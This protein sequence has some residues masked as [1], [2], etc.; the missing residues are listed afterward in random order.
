M[1]V[2]IYDIMLPEIFI[3]RI[4]K[5]LSYED[6]RNAKATCKKWREF[7]FTLYKIDNQ[8]K[9]KLRIMI[10]LYNFTSK[11]SASFLDKVA[12][13]N[14]VF[15]SGAVNY[16]RDCNENI[17]S[18]VE[19]IGR[20]TCN[21]PS[22]P[23]SYMMHSMTINNASELMVIGGKNEK[24]KHCYVY[25]GC[26]W[27]YHSSLNKSRVSFCSVSML[28]GIY[29][30]GCMPLQSDTNIQL[31]AEHLPNGKSI[32]Q[33]LDSRI[34]QPGI[35]AAHAVA[36]SP[37]EILFTGNKHLAACRRI[38]TFNISTKQWTHHG[39]FEKPRWFHSSFVYRIR[40]IISGG[41]DNFGAI[42]STEIITLQ[43]MSVKDG[44]DLNE[45][46]Y[47][48][49]MGIIE[50]NGIQRLVAFGG[51]DGHCK[52]KG[53]WLTSFEV[54]NDSLECWEKTDMKLSEPLSYFGYCSKPIF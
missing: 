7:I 15:V 36:I 39:H 33:N 18:K 53:K 25:K 27:V 19:V 4:F 10:S 17:P 45:A 2:N 16:G 49:G 9:C 42:N 38:L 35:T 44:G 13:H 8:T 28:D 31:T 5:Y 43:T 34:P 11:I 6:L 23:K 46:R 50:I 29:V 20:Y 3:Y 40:V 24:F 41:T 52:R 26:K 32:W 51:F 14:S 30:F 37:N 54:W 48:H 47:G 12:I 22:L 21:L 1:A